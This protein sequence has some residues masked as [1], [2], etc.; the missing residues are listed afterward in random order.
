MTSDITHQPVAADAPEVFPAAR[1]A[2]ELSVARASWLSAIAT[3]VAALAGALSIY[4][5]HKQELATFNTVI[6][7]KQIESIAALVALSEQTNQYAVLVSGLD[8]ARLRRDS[9]YFEYVKAKLTRRSESADADIAAAMQYFAMI[10]VTAPS[11][12]MGPVII[13]LYSKMHAGKKKAD[14]V[15][16]VLM[17]QGDPSSNALY[18]IAKNQKELKDLA[19]PIRQSH[20]RLLVCAQSILKNGKFVA[21]DSPTNCQ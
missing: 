18:D 9:K 11:D 6:F 19:E 3:L 1:R 7:G 10:A 13:D 20:N 2:S 5:A 17:R 14:E 21:E 8:F 16:Y 15:A 12:Q 4:T